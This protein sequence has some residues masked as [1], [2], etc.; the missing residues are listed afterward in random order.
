MASLTPQ[1]TVNFLCKILNH[2]YPN[3][4]TLGRQT[5]Q[6]ELFF[7]AVIRYSNAFITNYG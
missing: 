2:F 5:C 7:R 1:I 6:Y 3:S 4:C